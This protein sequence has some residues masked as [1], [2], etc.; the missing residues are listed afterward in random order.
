VAADF[1]EFVAKVHR[2]LPQTKIIYI[3]IKPSPSRHHLIDEVRSANQLIREL[4]AA[5]ERLFY[6]DVFSAMLNDQGAP[7]PELFI[8][9]DL[10]LNRQGYDLWTEIIKP[11]LLELMP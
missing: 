1:Q 2:A 6:I 8:E 7:R 3:S 11:R 4:T 5:D 10:H 9:D